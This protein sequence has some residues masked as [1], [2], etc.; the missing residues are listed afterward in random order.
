MGLAFG[1]AYLYASYIR[2]AYGL[3][4]SEV[5]LPWPLPPCPAQ[6]F[7]P[8]SGVHGGE[9]L[10][11][12]P[13]PATVTNNTSISANHQIFSMRFPFAETVVETDRP[14]PQL[15]CWPCLAE[16]SASGM[17]SASCYHVEEN[18]F[19]VAIVKAILKLREIQ[20][21]IFLAHIVVVCLPRHASTATKTI[22]CCWYGPRHERIDSR[23]A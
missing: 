7:P 19:V 13:Q 1:I 15:D 4:G 22:R 8:A 9:L 3:S 23:C 14:C 16:A 5:P 6:V 10:L 20:R 18:I 17:T 21:Q 12:L 2:G 11:L